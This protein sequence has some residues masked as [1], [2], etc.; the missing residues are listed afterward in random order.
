MKNLSLYNTSYFNLNKNL[1]V[2]N[3]SQ[4]FKLSWDKIDRNTNMVSFSATVYFKDKKGHFIVFNNKRFYTNNY[5][6]SL[7]TV[8]NEFNSIRFFEISF[9]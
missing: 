5:K 8:I 6:K 1:N 9:I 7:F 4:L 2:S 3:I